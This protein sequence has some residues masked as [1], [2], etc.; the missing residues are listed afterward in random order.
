MRKACSVW[1]P[2]T[3]SDANKVDRVQ[4]AATLV[5]LMDSH[6]K[7]D[8]LKYWA[9]ENETWMLYSSQRTKQENR[10]W[11]ARVDQRLT[12]VLSTLTN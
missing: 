4:C 7:E 6:S 2:H 1:I 3:L 9:V 10:A 12:I 11:Q 8:C 5:E